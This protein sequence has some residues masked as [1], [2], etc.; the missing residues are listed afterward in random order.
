[1]PK[2][3][4]FAMSQVLATHRCLLKAVRDSQYA[5]SALDQFAPYEVLVACQLQPG[6]PADVFLADWQLADLFGGML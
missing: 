3:G 5:A 1:M 6:E 4:A 2:G